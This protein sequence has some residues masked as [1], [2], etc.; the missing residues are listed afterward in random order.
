MEH[1]A[2]AV[3]KIAQM[4]PQDEAV[5]A[6]VEQLER[7]VSLLAEKMRDSK[8][9]VVKETMKDDIAL[10]NDQIKQLQTA[11]EAPARNYQRIVQI[12]A[13]LARASKIAE[14]ERHAAVRPKLAAC[15]AKVA[16]IFSE[17]D[18]T[19]DLDKHLEAVEKAVHALYGDQSKHST[20]YPERRGKG[21]HG[22]GE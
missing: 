12:L 16:G 6:T 22:E 14:Q 9:G 3:S 17:V 19:A 1:I 20:F 13:G 11:A 2:A 18:T 15:V 10:L 4:D 7:E 8:K 21:H 5:D